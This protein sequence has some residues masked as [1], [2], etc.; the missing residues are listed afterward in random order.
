MS[1]LFKYRIQRAFGA[2][3]IFAATAAASA[4]AMQYGGLPAPNA[5]TKHSEQKLSPQLRHV[6]SASSKLCR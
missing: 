1:S 6:L 5:Y 4:Q 3:A 2:A